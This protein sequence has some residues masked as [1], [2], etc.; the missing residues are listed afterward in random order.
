LQDKALAIVPTTQSGGEAIISKV[1][2]TDSRAGH[3][4]A[5]EINLR[6]KSVLKAADEI[7][8]NKIGELITGELNSYKASVKSYYGAIKDKAI[9]N[10][11]L[12]DFE[13]DSSRVALKPILSKLK[14]GITD[15]AVKERFA[16]QMKNAIKYVAPKRKKTA[17][18]KV[19]KDYTV[20]GFENLL[21]LR[22]VVNDFLHNK[23]IVKKPDFD[24][25][26]GVLNNIDE[27]IA[28]GAKRMP[29][30]AQ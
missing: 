1:A 22:G 23:K 18:G 15:P 30:G 26:R 21:E 19:I 11:D 3:V 9:K 17:E 24:A 14:E 8:D 7:A 27:L 6:A 12:A 25:V 16:L 13:F 20:K 28:E 4:I 10:P 5:N 2:S 29:N